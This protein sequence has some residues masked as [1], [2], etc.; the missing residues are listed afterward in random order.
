MYAPSTWVSSGPRA[1]SVRHKHTCLSF[2]NGE[3]LLFYGGI[4]NAGT[5]PSQ[6]L[7]TY[8]IG[9]ASISLVFA[10]LQPPSSLQRRPLNSS[11]TFLPF[12]SYS[13]PNVLPIGLV[14]AARV[15]NTPVPRKR[16]GEKQEFMVRKSSSVSRSSDDG[17][18]LEASEY[19]PMKE[20]STVMEN[21]F[22]HT[23]V[24]WD[25][26]MWVFGGQIL[27][28][29]TSSIL[30][31]GIFAYS[32]DKND[33]WHVNPE[34]VGGVFPQPRRGHTAVVF[35]DAMFVVGGCGA[36]SEA[37]NDMWMYS[38]K[39]NNWTKIN[40]T[41]SIPSAR[42]FHTAEIVGH[43][44]YLFG[45][46][47]GHKDL[48][49]FYICNMTTFKWSVIELSGE[50]QIKPPAKHAAKLIA[51]FSGNLLL[52]GGTSALD[53]NA[54]DLYL[55]HT[56]KAAWF[57]QRY[58][59]EES[60]R[61][62]PQSQDS[63][64]TRFTRTESLMTT[65]KR[66]RVFHTA[67]MAGA[68]AFSQC[69]IFVFGGVNGQL[70]NVLDV[71]SVEFTD[72]QIADLDPLFDAAGGTDTTERLNNLPKEQ[73]EAAA[74]YYNPEILALRERLR[75][76]T[77]TPSFARQ[78]STG[79]TQATST[80][81]NTEVLMLIMEWLTLNGYAGTMDKLAKETR[82]QFVKLHDARGSALEL[83]LS[84]ARRRIKRGTGIWDD[85]VL[86]LVA[87]SGVVQAIDHLPDWNANQW[88][89]VIVS[90]NPWDEVITEDNLRIDPE[91]K[92][93]LF[94]TL[95]ALVILTLD[96][97]NFVN[98]NAT[99]EEVDDYVSCFFHTYHAF[100]T[101]M[102][103]LEKYIQLF[104]VSESEDLSDDSVITHRSRILEAILVWI[105]LA[106]WDW[107]NEYLV[108][109]LKDFV[110]G[111]L[112]NTDLRWMAPQIKQALAVAMEHSNS[113]TAPAA[114]AGVIT[115]TGKVKS[116]FIT[117]NQLMAMNPLPGT[118][119]LRAMILEQLDE[120]PE[121]VVRKNIF[122]P[123]HTL[124]DVYEVELARQMTIMQFS[125]FCM[126]KPSELLNGWWKSDDGDHRTPLVRVCLN[127][128]TV[129]SNW[130]IASFSKPGDDK[131]ARGK[132]VERAF[133]LAE[134]L[135][136]LNNLETLSAVLDG[137]RH[138]PDE[139]LDRIDKRALDALYKL[140]TSIK[141]HNELI[142]SLDI[143]TPC[144]PNLK[145]VLKYIGKVEDEAELLIVPPTK[146]ARPL[147]NMHKCR[148]LHAT[149]RKFISFQSR[150]YNFLPVYQIIAALRNPGTMAETS[151]TSL[152][153]IL[154]PRV[155]Q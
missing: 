3:M 48:N 92:R 6:V 75:M 72:A 131:K 50:T 46:F 64:A 140:D 15:W 28:T 97:A 155:Q 138:A 133:K 102:V 78:T 107:I 121:P 110:D 40:Q 93:I 30:S 123:H 69:E 154:S 74:M 94:G 122:S 55:Y 100:T 5:A 137:L 71:I 84:F 19:V 59:M 76:L 45:G 25:N 29:G 12:F 43:Y 112:V 101:P 87:N 104:E 21:R 98:P 26:C 7:L 141:E 83:L 66:N 120:P 153:I 105:D 88:R 70:A 41:G 145:L 113:P 56:K 150:F 96:Y 129:I 47:D 108:Q 117:T 130:I 36:S 136:A 49:D 44:L 134:Q 106:S 119:R 95:N 85:S 124:D 103:L 127:R 9:M 86:S 77:G 31:N 14:L 27:T 8:D 80:L 148:T 22:G 35:N 16:A 34:A 18:D 125:L 63:M 13:C 114:N 152:R 147:V 11:L 39:D 10:R 81:G 109:K 53:D 23:A 58:D 116:Q 42:L 60:L 139:L 51:L 142:D 62:E 24:M 33:F 89:D 149:L 32:V 37:Y 2:Q 126:I 146:N 82:Q 1:T 17:S 151:T 132:A 143:L 115:N 54:L 57:L 61:P 68:S 65:D 20:P 144:I 135:R 79:R 38:F 73:W 4:T 90:Q 99:T 91:T 52:V 118:Q 111:P 128:H 67:V